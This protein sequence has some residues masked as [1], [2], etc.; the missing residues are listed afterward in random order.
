[1]A[2]LHN[3]FEPIGG[4]E[5]NLMHWVCPISAAQRWAEAR[6]P[7]TREGRRVQ[8]SPEELTRWLGRESAGEPDQI[9]TENPSLFGCG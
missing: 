1:M 7:I 9:A 6:M 8:P 2:G 3:G 4:L 5:A